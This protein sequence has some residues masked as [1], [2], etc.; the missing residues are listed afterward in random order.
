MTN[1]E[2]IADRTAAG[3]ALAYRSGEAG[4]VALTECLLDRIAKAKGDHIFITVTGERALAEAK[5]AEARYRKGMPLSPLDGVP[6]AWKDLFD[7]AGAPTTAGSNL[8]RGNPPKTRDLLCVANAA[9]AGI[10]SV[11]KVNLTEFAYSGLGLNPHFGTPR[12]PNDRSTPRSPGGSSSGSG[13][14]VAARL[15]PCAIGTDTGGSVRIPSAFNGVVGFKTSTGRIDTT[16]LVPLARSY[17]TIGPLAR[18]VEDCVLVDM[19]LRG[20]VTTSVRRRDPRSLVL[21]VP[22]NLIL[23]QAESE[24]A[25]N[26]ERS[27]A[28]LASAGATIRRERVEVL[29]E[30]VE[31]TARFG[32]LTAA[33]AYHEYK[34]IVDS[35]KANAVDRRVIRRMLD[36][37]RMSANDL[38]SIHRGR[39]R[40]IPKLLAQLGEALLVMPTTPITAPEVAPLDADDELFHKVNLR[41][42]SNTQFGNILDLCAVALPNGHGANRMPTSILFSAGN[43]EDERLLGHSLEIER[44]LNAAN[45]AQ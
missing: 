43:G 4:P 26:F 22:T 13:T 17:D 21:L 10:V 8:L 7:V 31:M 12:N 28:A 42:L 20:A 27:L 19:A 1:I 35:D 39:E 34:D 15:V 44:T 16:G 40:L 9:A 45:A 24:V 2:D 5:A 32:T 29:D 11:G 14:A 37:K 38:L 23:D 6:I 36:G 33:E 25:G 3:M 41:T 30:V 18:S